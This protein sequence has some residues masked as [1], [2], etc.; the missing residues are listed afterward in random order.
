MPTK[1]HPRDKYDDEV[2]Y[3]VE[4]PERV[5]EW[6]RDSKPPFQFCTPSGEW[7][8][9]VDSNQ[10][11]GCPTMVRSGTD[12]AWNDELTLAIRQDVTL[13]KDIDEFQC[14]LLAA[15][16]EVRRERLNVFAKWQRRF[17]RE[18]RGGAA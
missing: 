9:R 6:W 17:D 11:C 7:C 14:E 1:T 10:S 5:H 15:T 12:V 8:L 2:D 3:L 4:H 16:P 13:P 18:I